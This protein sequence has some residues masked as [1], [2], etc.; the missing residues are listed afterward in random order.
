MSKPPI[1]RIDQNVYRKKGETVAENIIAAIYPTIGSHS[2]H[3]K[4][5]KNIFVE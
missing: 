5:T 3:V 2:V 1:V 4:I